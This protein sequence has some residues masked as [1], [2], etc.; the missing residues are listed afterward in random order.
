M[1]GP[2]AAILDNGERLH[3]QHGPIDLLIGAEGNATE[4]RDKAFAAAAR[5]FDG[6]LE[7]LVAHLDQCRAQLFQTSAVPDNPV[8]QRMFSAAR[9]HCATDFVTPMIAVAGAV[10]D[11]ILAAMLRGVPLRR[12]YVN[13]GG[14]IAV[15]LGSDARF[16]VA[17]A[18]DT[19]KD[20]GRLEIGA[21]DSI[22]GVATSGAGGRS[23]SFGIADSV[24]V[25][26]RNSAAA[27]AAATLIANAVDLPDHPGIIR[28]PACDLQP[29][30]DLGNR[31][32]VTSVPRLGHDEKLWALQAGQDKA[33][34]L[35]HSGNIFGAALFL[36]G[37]SVQA[38]SPF[39]QARALRELNYA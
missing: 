32:V 15:H 2:V 24:T 38:G 37:E 13:N 23:L 3:L 21:E 1:Q 6:L 12:A 17:M 16:S 26:A 29:D 7:G 14:D 30:S 34:R 4:A 35:V 39:T 11:E 19:G 25:L 36:Q 27:D 10:A 8:A 33:W 20:L 9:V 28:I 5:C 22:G 31:P 18:G